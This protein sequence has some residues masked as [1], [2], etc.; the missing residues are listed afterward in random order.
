MGR[1]LLRDSSDAMVLRPR[2]GYLD[3][4]LLYASHGPSFEQ[5]VCYA[6]TERRRPVKL[7]RCRSKWDLAGH[8]REL[9]RRILELDLQADLTEH[10][11]TVLP[12]E[13]RPPY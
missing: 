10:L 1:N 4:S 2:G 13:L 8:Q 5:G 12:V 11:Q 9:G 6:Y 3:Q 7:E